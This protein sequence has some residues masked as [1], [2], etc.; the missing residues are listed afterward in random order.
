MMDIREVIA[1]DDAQ[2]ENVLGGQE[3]VPSVLQLFMD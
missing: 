3:L 1:V 2:L